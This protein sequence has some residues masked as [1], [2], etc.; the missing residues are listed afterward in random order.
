ME[1]GR[2]DK[3]AA[4]LV[5]VLLAAGWALPGQLPPRPGERDPL[6]LQTR[7]ATV[8]TALLLEYYHDLPEPASEEDPGKFAVRMDRALKKFHERIEARYTE[9]TLQ[10][11]LDNPATEVRRA[12]ALGLGLI[13]SMRCNE[14]LAGRLHDDDDVVRRLAAEA[15]WSVW[16]RAD[17][18]ANNAELDRLTRLR[19]PDKALAGL[20]ALIRKAPNFA[21]AYNQRAIRH[22]QAKEYEKA[23]ADCEQVLKLN[24]YH[25]GAASGMAQSYVLLRKPKEALK[26]YREAY[27]L[28]PNMDGVLDAIRTLE[29]ILGEEGDK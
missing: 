12:A 25:F 26:A 18:D 9:G 28:N 10:R 2:W 5:V 17:S 29:N 4:A 19:D 22:Y 6:C 3:G 27:R 24:P 13:G 14:S 21:E 8:G 1:R 7:G 23:V 11:L 16:F 15:L 20:D